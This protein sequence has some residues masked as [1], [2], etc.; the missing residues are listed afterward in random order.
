MKYM[1]FLFL[2]AGIIITSYI[3]RTKT[4]RVARKKRSSEAVYMAFWGVVLVSLVGLRS[5]SVGNDTSMYGYIFNSI[6]AT[7]SFLPW[8]ARSIYTSNTEYGFY[9]VMYL[10]SRFTDYQQ[11]I[12]ISAIITVT[13][14][15]YL[16]YKYSHN[17]MLSL[18]L[19][20]CFPYYTF[21][22]SGLRQAY[23][24]SFIAVAY[25]FIVDK[26]PW[27]FIISCI[28]GTL[29]HQSAILFIPVYWI[30][31]I[32]NTKI[33][34]KAAII[35]I[36]ASYLLR[37]QIWSFAT[38]FARQQYEGNE[39]GG[40]MMCLF[41]ILCAILGIYYRRLFIDTRDNV[42]REDAVCNKNSYGVAPNALYAEPRKELLYLQILAAM[43]APLS[44]YNS[45][46]SRVYYYYH[47]F[48]ILY[49]PLLLKSITN[50]KER[51]IIEAGY[52]VVA[53]YFLVSIIIN[54]MNKYVPYTF[55]WQ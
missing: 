12:F 19:Y 40:Q 11:F 1:L 20:V 3:L 10:F 38:T 34:R 33:T 6:R 47:I 22:M 4:V 13:P 43:I 49:V 24:L 14:Y 15:I 27:K 42:K 51:L 5:S 35:A 26:K 37:N 32:K 39:A 28:L 31:K 54:P 9:F 25:I 55:F 48:V 29:C 21:N 52:I 8:M 41:L 36:A 7:D 45:A 50:K 46:I 53:I 17:K 30:G 16:I 23:A 18:L 44:L 2:I